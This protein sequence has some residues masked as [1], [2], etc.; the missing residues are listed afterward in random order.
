MDLNELAKQIYEGNKVKGF[1]K[2]REGVPEKM[3]ESGL[4]SEEEISSVIKAFKCQALML[5]VSELSEAMESDRK[6]KFAKPELIQTDFSNERN[7]NPTD[8]QLKEYFIEDFEAHVKDTFEDE[9]ADTI[10]RLLD[11]CGGNGIDIE[12]HIKEKLKYN[13]TRPKMHGKNY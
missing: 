7:S 6:D 2:N 1:W 5:T 10:I 4:F 9:M 8:Q 11:F 3:K 13:A 12:F